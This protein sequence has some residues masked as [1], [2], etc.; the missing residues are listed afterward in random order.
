M[1]TIDLTRFCADE[2]L[3]YNLD[4]PWVRGGY[5]IATDGRICVR[6]KTDEPDTVPGEGERYPDIDA[7]FKELDEK[8]A[9]WHPMP[10]ALPYNAPSWDNCPVCGGSA[11]LGCCPQCGMF[12][13]RDKDLL[14]CR[15]C[16]G[17]GTLELVC[18]ITLD[19]RRY[20]VEYIRDIMSLPA[21]EYGE[22]NEEAARRNPAHNPL[23][24]RFDGGDGLLMGLR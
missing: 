7:L 8:I 15:H 11:Q 2:N 18:S 9:A 23:A 1:K 6:V 4:H 13:G 19:K 20:S 14:D 10:T 21:L 12:G 5:K 24:F 3:R 22:L 17:K 16:D